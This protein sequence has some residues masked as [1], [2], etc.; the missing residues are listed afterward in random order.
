MSLAQPPGM[1]AT[2]DLVRT[3]D[4]PGPRYTSYPT[5]VEFTEQFGQRAYLER[6]DQAAALEHEPLSLYV[7]LP[8][9]EARCSF[10]GCSVIVTEKRWVAARYLEYLKREIELLGSRLKGRRHVVQHHWGGGTPTYFEPAQLADLFAAISRH[11]DLDPRGEIA[12]EVDPRATTLEHVDTLRS[13]GFNRLSLGVQDFTERVQEAINRRQPEAHTRG[14]FSYAREA[15]F[16]SIN[17]DLI[18]GLPFQ[19]LDTFGRTVEAVIDMRPE[20]LAVYSYAHVPWIRGN[21][22]RIDPR[23]LPAAPL[24][25]ELFS[26]A[27]EM[28]H[29]AGYTQIGMDH[30]AVPSDELAR[31]AASGTLYRNFMGYTTRPAADMLGAGISAIGEVRHAFAQNTKKLSTYY[32]ALDAGWFPIERGLAL[33]ADDLV[34]RHVITQLMCNFTVRKADLEGRFGVSFDQY[35]AAELKE[36]AAPDGPLGFGFV[37]LA[38]DRV[39][40]LPPGRRFVRNVC[41]AFDRYLRSHD[42]APVFSRTV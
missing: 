32:A 8:F 9:C 35:F 23:D 37:R 6:L 1:L 15:G 12:I 13:L 3:F 11:F 7:H 5:A 17:V 42:V 31:A 25:F 10:C 36:L 38:H 18:Y 28:L 14:L 16:E 27:L 4:R 29:A 39:D 26:V 2:P 30:F 41:M 20:R 40:V 22:K 33:G 19:T 34:R 21:Q 24:K